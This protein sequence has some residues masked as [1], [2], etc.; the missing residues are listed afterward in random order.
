MAEKPVNEHLW[1]T[2]VMQAKQK[3]AT[4]P[5]PGASHFVHQRYVELGG[6]FETHDENSRLRDELKKKFQ[7]RI[8]E[9]AAHSNQ[10][11]D[12][13]KKPKKDKK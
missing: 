3:Y 8:R 4:Y 9:K 10:A 7:A 6:K 5:S 12:K 1:A 13:D 2:V 11:K